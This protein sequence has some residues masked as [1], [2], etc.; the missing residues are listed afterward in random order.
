MSDKPL[1]DNPVV[2]RWLSPSDDR[3][4]AVLGS[5]PEREM[6]LRWLEHTGIVLLP[7]VDPELTEEVLLWN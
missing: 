3:I 1:S 7:Q 5:G 4:A 6:H 2:I